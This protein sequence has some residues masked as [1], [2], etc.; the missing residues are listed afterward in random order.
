MPE[1][2]PDK[3]SISR[4]EAFASK[5]MHDLRMVSEEGPPSRKLRELFS[6]GRYAELTE[7]VP[8]NDVV[9]NVGQMATEFAMARRWGNEL[10]CLKL[11]DGGFAPISMM[12]YLAGP[13]WPSYGSGQG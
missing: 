4:A 8:I 2:E 12:E 5:L 11:D 7:G 1:F 9:T 3:E 6:E 13:L 10:L